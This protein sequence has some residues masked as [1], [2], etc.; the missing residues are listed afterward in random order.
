VIGEALEEL[1]A[2]VRGRVVAEEPIAPL[3][4]FRLGGPAGILVE[5][6]SE[7]DLL[8]IAAAR[9]RHQLPVLALG[10]GTN[11][12]VSDRGFR[13]IVLRLGAGFDWIAGEGRMVEAGSATPLPRVANWAARRGLAGLEFATA[14]PAT[15]GG[16]VRMNAGAHGGSMADVLVSARVCRMSEQRVVAMPAGMLRLRY[17]ETVLT[18][19]DLVCSA[20]FELSEESTAG[21]LARMA[22]YRAHRAAT[23]PVEAPNAGS[24][25]RN[26]EGDSAGRLIEAAG[27][28][29]HRVGAAEVSTKH[30]NFFLAHPGATAQQVHDLMALV[31][32]TVRDRFG[33][34]LVPEIRIMGEFDRA[35]A[36]EA[37]R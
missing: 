36:L 23:Q 30:A 32:R 7:D 4:S 6:E 34:V 14:I 2:A 5:A 25:F 20:R 27:L 15:V 1:R 12:L 11:L 3:T 10:R 26:P 33:V 19:D 37:G 35:D 31:Q 24:M 16:G 29:G 13:G 9:A 8:A 21:I 17:R 18:A 28:K 22:G